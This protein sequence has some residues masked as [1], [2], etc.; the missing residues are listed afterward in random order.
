MGLLYAEIEVGSRV[1]RGLSLFTRYGLVRSF[2]RRHFLEKYK[3]FAH[4]SDTFTVE[5]V[6]NAAL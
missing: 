5:L 2:C 3:V 4:R 1:Q 6:D